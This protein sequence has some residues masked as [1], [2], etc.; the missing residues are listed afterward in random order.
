MNR[1]SNTNLGPIIAMI[2]APFLAL[3]FGMLVAKGSYLTLGAMVV[4]VI[5]LLLLGL[6]HKH[7]LLIGIMLATL[8]FWAAPAGFKMNAMEQSG[9]FAFAFWLLIFWRKDFNPDAPGAFRQLTSWGFFKSATFVACGYAFIHFMFNKWNPYEPLAFGFKGAIK[10]YAQVF[11]PFLMIVA[12]MGSQLLFPV[13]RKK[14]RVLLRAFSLAFFLILSI[15]LYHSLRYGMVMEEGL[16]MGERQ[17]SYRGFFIPGLNIWDNHYTLR[18]MGPAATL[19]GGVFFLLPKGI[20]KKTLPLLLILGGALGSALS[21]GRAALIFSGIFLAFT[22]LRAGKQAEIFMGGALLA[23]VAAVVLILPTDALKEL[24]YFMQRSVGMIRTDLKTE[25]T[26]SI[27]GSSDMRREYFKYAWDYWSS[28]DARLVLLGRSVGEMDDSDIAMFASG[29]ASVIFFAIRRIATHNGLTD[30]LVGWGAVGYILNIIVWISCCIMLFRFNRMFEKGSYGDCWS[31]IAASF[32]T[33][34]LVYMHIG[35]S[36][37]WPIAIWFSLVALTQT[38]GLIERKKQ[39]DKEQDTALP[40][41]QGGFS[42][43]LHPNL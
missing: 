20:S 33:F 21:G 29:D 39:K 37:V 28:G 36:F 30:T 11:G 41:P 18:I 9:A 15:R 42:P 4:A 23:I 40:S 6:A 14:S 32:M 43:A 12:I 38:D 2:L 19:V 10:T 25:A 24:P 3:W 8:D 22:A 27:E 17:A 1:S 5:G 34:W 7:L 16:N 26:A 13:D 35:G 31:F